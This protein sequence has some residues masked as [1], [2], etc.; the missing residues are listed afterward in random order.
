M[1]VLTRPPQDQ[2]YWRVHWRSASMA[3]P[4]FAYFAAEEEALAYAERVAAGGGIADVYRTD[5]R[6]RGNVLVRSFLPACQPR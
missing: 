4:A 3:A 1:E 6:N 2:V 5:P